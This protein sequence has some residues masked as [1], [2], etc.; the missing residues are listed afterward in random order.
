MR[1]RSK[2]RSS[3]MMSRSNSTQK[4]EDKAETEVKIKIISNYG[5]SRSTSIPN[6]RFLAWKMTEL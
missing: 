3:Y 1:L 5:I 6:F 4:V 2:S